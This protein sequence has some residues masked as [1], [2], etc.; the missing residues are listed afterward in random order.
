MSL[1]VPHI[2]QHKSGFGS[3]G[4]FQ[5]TMRRATSFYPLKKT[6]THLR[7][8][9][10]DLTNST[11]TA[12]TKPCAGLS[13]GCSTGTSV[14][15]CILEKHSS[16]LRSQRHVLW[17]D[18]SVA[19]ALLVDFVSTV[20][21]P[22]KRC[23][24]STSASE[25]A[26]FSATVGARMAAFFIF[27][28]FKT[29]ATWLRID[30][31]TRHQCWNVCDWETTEKDQPRK[32]QL[33]LPTCTQRKSR[34]QPSNRGH[35]TFEK[36]YTSSSQPSKPFTP[37]GWHRRRDGTPRSRSTPCLNCIK[38]SKEKDQPTQLRCQNEVAT[39]PTPSRLLVDFPRFH[40][41]GQSAQNAS[42]IPASSK[43]QEK[44]GA[45]FVNW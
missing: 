21:G 31:M 14:Y 12:A 27:L 1:Y 7:S 16:H 28:R 4:T 29:Q 23:S 37:T 6:A 2:P 17:L 18:L 30:K 32:A 45:S 9:Y 13:D 35:H 5:N 42:N 41:C 40:Q 20:C 26:S 34:N 44:T 11:G 33:S 19:Q 15:N 39:C 3:L 43:T 36:R 38:I 22:S 24:C 25:H 8:L 10:Q